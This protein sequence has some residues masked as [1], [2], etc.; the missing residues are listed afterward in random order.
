MARQVCAA[1]TTPADGH[2][3]DAGDVVATVRAIRD[4]DIDADQASWE[5]IDAHARAS[6]DQD[7]QEVAARLI[8]A[9][10]SR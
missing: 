6:A 7:P 2:V 10:F 5:R 4:A 8:A 1:D 9:V 3:K